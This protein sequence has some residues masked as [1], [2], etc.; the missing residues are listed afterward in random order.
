[1]FDVKLMNANKAT[2]AAGK[3]PDVVDMGADFSNAIAPNMN[4]E[5]VL[6]MPATADVV[7]TIQSSDK[8]DMTAAKD[9]AKVT[10]KKGARNGFTVVPT[11]YGRYVGATAEGTFTGKIN[12]GLLF[13]VMSPQGLGLAQG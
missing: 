7:V 1:M 13:G 10:V 12:A 11:V 8:S 9:I 3:L 5:V 2:Y 6:S 4:Y